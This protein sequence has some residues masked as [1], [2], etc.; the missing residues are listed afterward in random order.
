VSVQSQEAKQIERRAFLRLGCGGKAFF[1]GSYSEFWA[2]CKNIS[3]GGAAVFTDANVPAAK[4]LDLRID[5]G[6]YG[7]VQALGK[8]LRSRGGMLGIRFLVLSPASRF[9]IAAFTSG[10]PP[11]NRIVH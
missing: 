6:E 8:V 7:Q 10:R 3:L 1:E 11:G 9:A 4:V 5:L 2:V